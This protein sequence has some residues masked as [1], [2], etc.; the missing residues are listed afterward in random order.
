VSISKAKNIWTFREAGQLIRLCAWI[1]AVTA[2]IVMSIVLYDR[3]S[4]ERTT[5][6]NHEAFNYLGVIIF[7]LL[8]GII[9]QI[10]Y[11]IAYGVDSHKNW[12]RWAG[13]LLA[14]IYLIEFP[15]GAIIG[16]LILLHLNKGWLAKDNLL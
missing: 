13:N 15:A 2:L 3:I 12:G 1:S 5:A 8:L 7:I 11:A 16:A 6:I 9:L 4:G 14:V 10:Q